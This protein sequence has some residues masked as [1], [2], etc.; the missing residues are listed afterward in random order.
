MA[1][2]HGVARLPLL[3]RLE[4]LQELDFSGRV[5]RDRQAVP[6]KNPVAG[7]RG[8]ARPGRDDAQKIQRIGPGERDELAGVGP[9]ARGSRVTES[10]A[11]GAPVCLKSA[12]HARAYSSEFR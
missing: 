6:I 4:L 5:G 2:K 11:I 10:R 12:L 8:Q 1:A 7:K 3:L 9:A